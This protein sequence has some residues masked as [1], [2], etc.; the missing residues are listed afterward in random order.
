MSIQ[1]AGAGRAGSMGNGIAQACAML[2]LDAVMVDISGNL[3]E[4]GIAAAAAGRLD[5]ETGHLAYR[6]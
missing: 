6:L 1:K 5:R 2:G 4:K 3:V